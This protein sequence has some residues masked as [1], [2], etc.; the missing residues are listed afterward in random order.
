MDRTSEHDLRGPLLLPLGHNSGGDNGE[1]KETSQR[2]KPLVPT[3]LAVC[4]QINAEARDILYDHVFYM[5]D[6]HTMH[7]FIVNLG[8]RAAKFIKDVR[9]ESWGTGRRSAYHHVSWAVIHIRCQY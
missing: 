1:R 2:A 9:L 6:A 4:K 5:D 7:S 8:P 3:L